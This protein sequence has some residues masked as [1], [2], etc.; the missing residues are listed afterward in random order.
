K[1]MDVAGQQR[2]ATGITGARDDA[3]FEELDDVE[4]LR[5][6]RRARLSMAWMRLEEMIDRRAR[7][8]LPALVE[9]DARHHAGIIRAPHARHEEW[10]LGRRHDAS[11]RS[12]DVGEAVADVGRAARF[13]ATADRADAAGM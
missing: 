1:D 13:V 2:G 5:A 7:G 9:P 10:L 12:H 6:R 11:R 3:P 8:G 4:P